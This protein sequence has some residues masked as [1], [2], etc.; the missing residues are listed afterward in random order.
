MLIKL[1]LDAKNSLKISNLI[2]CSTF[3]KIFVSHSFC[4]RDHIK[5]SGG[6]EGNK[7]NNNIYC[8]LG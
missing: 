8:A 7:N 5:H 1:Y 4:T 6:G 3:T 2:K